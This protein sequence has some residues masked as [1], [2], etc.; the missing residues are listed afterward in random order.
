[1]NY[2]NNS[3]LILILSAFTMYACNTDSLTEKALTELNHTLK[4]QPEFIKVHAAEYLIWLGHT[5]E[6]RKEFLHENE[7]HGSQPK[8]RIGIW[9][10]LSQA[11]KDPAGKKVWNDKVYNAFGDLNG[12]DRL[13]ASETLAKLKLSPLEKYPE[14]TQKSMADESRNLQVYTHWATF[15]SPGADAKKYRQ[16]FLNLVANDSNKIIRMIS[17]YVLRKIKGLD[18]EQWTALARVALSEP[19]SSGLRKN[20]INTAIVTF[21]DGMKSTPDYEKIRQEMTRNYEQFSAGE[22][23]E[24]AQALAEEGNEEDLKLLTSYLNNENSAG[25][26]EPGSKEGADVRAAAAFAILKIAQR[27][28]SKS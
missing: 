19:D 25:V 23:I 3:F 14:A 22:R 17:A 11:E 15:Y 9:R 24:L 21:P 28:G 4:T 5:E 7:L 1:M 8:Y 6:A 16:D 12:P 27:S 13:H 10:V 26:Y 2:K 18:A 20:L